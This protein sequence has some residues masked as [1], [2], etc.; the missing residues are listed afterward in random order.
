M[1]VVGGRMRLRFRSLLIA[2]MLG[3]LLATVAVIAVTSYVA[4]RATAED[5]SSQVLAQT[6]ERVRDRVE[7]E[8]SVAVAE[9]ELDRERVAS[10]A[11]DSRDQAAL[12]GFFLDEIAAHP[13][14]T[15]LG[16]SNEADGNHLSAKRDPDGSLGLFQLTRNASTGKLVFEQSRVDTGDHTKREVVL[17]YDD[18]PEN[19]PRPR[20]YYVVAK[21]VHAPTWIET[22]MFLG[23]AG[24]AAVPGLTRATPIYDAS[25]RLIGVLDA[26]FTLDAL[27]RFLAELHVGAR[28]FAFVVEL[29]SDGERRVIAHPDPAVLVD[30]KAD[31]RVN[32]F[33]PVIDPSKGGELVPATF[34]AGGKE[35]LGSYRLVDGD[36]GLH[37]VVAIALPRDEILGPVDAQRTRTFWIMIVALLVALVTA[38]LLATQIGAAIRRLTRETEA[39][40]QFEIDA[41]PIEESRV[42]E[43]RQLST[44]IEDMKRGLRAFRKFV[45]ADL[46][47]GLVQSG[48]EAVQG[49]V[50][51]TI[52]VHFSD[53]ANFTTISESLA[54]EALV[55]LLSEYL[56][57]MSAPILASGGTIDKYIG[58]AVMA[59][60]NAPRA[61][62]DHAF[63]ACKA[64][65]ANRD[66][67]AIQRAAWIAAGRPEVRCRV[68]LHTGDA[69][70]GNIGSDARLDFTAIGDTVNLAS[71]LEGLN[72]AYGTEILLSESTYELVKDRV[73]ARPL[74][75]VAVKGK[76]RG[77]LIYELLGLAGD[78]D[79]AGVAAAARH[80][81]A[82]SAYFARQWDEAQALLG[83]DAA[84]L[85]IA[86]RIETF[87]RVPPPPDWDGV[88]RMTSK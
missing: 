6:S 45:P 37:W 88:H 79:D 85:V 63:V 64:V 15:W 25:D 82:L 21:Q 76:E 19:D 20:P 9:A 60:W 74:D 49:G 2:V 14:L 71:R 13:Q 16:W 68:G 81:R 52:T 5:L 62:D 26:D 46:V 80:A 18:K 1:P 11:L 39:I 61:V 44:A 38:V 42:V 4:G 57:I 23:N 17:H 72:K 86:T 75:R 66:I 8:L 3:L 31:A 27:S 29:R 55:E 73:V 40:A 28:G 32:A 67:L 35:Y 77:I 84:A 83:G 59:F 54:P 41:K 70:V 51:K 12:A 87:T 43:V 53:I 58:D 10:K 78:V 36:R 24:V 50:R 56:S 47:R 7:G 48:D 22:H 69:V 34:A 30:A 33:L 65:L